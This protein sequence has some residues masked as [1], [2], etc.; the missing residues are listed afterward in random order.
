MKEKLLLLLLTMA[1]NTANAQEYESLHAKGLTIKYQKRGKGT[2]LILLHGLMQDS[3][4]WKTQV[5]S[6]SE[7]FTVIAWDAPGAGR[8][9]DPPETFTIKDWADCLASLMDSEHIHRANILGLSWGGFVAQAFYQYYPDRVLS[10]I[11]ADTSPGWKTLSDSTADALFAACKKDASLPVKDFVSKYLPGLFSDSV[12]QNV[13]ETQADIMADFHPV[14][15][16]LMA[17]TLAQGDMRSLLPQIKVPSLVI[18]G[19]ADKRSPIAAAYQFKN[20]I[21]GARLEIIPKA[22]HVCNMEKPYQFNNVVKGF[23]ESVATKK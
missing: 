2:A 3:R 5:D 18:W 13:K 20:A 19:E 23:C 15:F 11:L 8:S 14:G 17:A 22:R 21:H 7:H 10:L 4:I 9:A 12:R 6:L 1:L 16:R